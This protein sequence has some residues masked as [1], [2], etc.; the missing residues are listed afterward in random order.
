VAAPADESDDAPSFSC[1]KRRP[2]RTTSLAL[3][4]RPDATSAAMKDASSGGMEMFRAARRT[5][6]DW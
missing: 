1:N 4:Y 2:T 3:P 5:I 6:T